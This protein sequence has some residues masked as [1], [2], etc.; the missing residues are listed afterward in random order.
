MAGFPRP[1]VSGSRVPKIVES[2]LIGIFL[3]RPRTMSGLLSLEQ[4]TGNPL[5]ALGFI[6]RST[7]RTRRNARM[8]ELERAGYSIC[9]NHH[10]CNSRELQAHPHLIW[11][12]HLTPL[13]SDVKTRGSM[14]MHTRQLFGF[15]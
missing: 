7:V 5:V 12:S 8:S 3:D 9:P 4:F 6:L 14:G 10:G 11:L 13:N 2:V 15:E 1:K